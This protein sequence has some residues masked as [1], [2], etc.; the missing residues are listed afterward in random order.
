VNLK[1][2]PVSVGAFPYDAILPRLRQ[3]LDAIIAERR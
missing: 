1:R 2:G 3:E